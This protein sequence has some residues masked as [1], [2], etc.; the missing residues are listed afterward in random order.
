MFSEYIKIAVANILNESSQGIERSCGS[1][2]PSCDDLTRFICFGHSMKE[3]QDWIN[4][5]PEKLHQQ[6]SDNENKLYDDY[7]E[8][9]RQSQE[10]E[11]LSFA[12]TFCATCSCFVAAKE[13]ALSEHNSVFDA[14]VDVEMFQKG[15]M[16]NCVKFNEAFILYGMEAKENAESCDL[17][18]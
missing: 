8:Y 17:F 10:E 11:K 7:A 4:A 5:N 12:K 15:C 14:V 13:K 9:M 16:K 6:Y 1:C 2:N 3:V 18:M